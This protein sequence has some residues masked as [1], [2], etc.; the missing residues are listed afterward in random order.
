[1]ATHK[2]D[3]WLIEHTHNTARFFTE[4]P[5]IAWVVLAATIGWGI[6]GYMNMPQRKDPDFPVRQAFVI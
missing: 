3:N 5:H 1:M 4:H 2:S 6:F